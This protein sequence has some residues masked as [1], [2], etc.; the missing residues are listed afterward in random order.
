[1]SEEESRALRRAANQRGQRGLSAL[2]SSM[3]RRQAIGMGVVGGVSLYLF[4]CG[5]SDGDSTSAGTV[6][7]ATE[8]STKPEQLIVRNWGDPWSTTWQASAGK[9]FE[10]DT[11]IKVVWDTTDGQVIQSKIQTAIRADSRPPVDAVVNIETLSYLSSVQGLSLAMNPDLIP[12]IASL[13]NSTAHPD[14]L[15]DW[16]YM[17]L[18]TYLH[19]IVYNS[20]KMDAP[21]SWEDLY[22]PSLAGRIQMTSAYTSVMYP[23]AKMLGLTP[24]EDDMGP[25]WD[26][27]VELRPNIGGQGDSTDFVKGAVS[28]DYWCG[29][30]LA[31]DAAAAVEQGVPIKAAVPKE[32]AVLDRDCYYVLNNLP[33]EV[34]YYAQVFC[35]YMV[36]KEAQTAIMSKNKVVPVNL[37]VELSKEMQADPRVYPF[38]EDEVAEVGIIPTPS[39]A[40]KHDADWQAQYDRAVKG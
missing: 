18:Y 9:A 38:T 14:G 8:P 31:G 22:D 27:I 17:G 11:G 13:N 36:S 10:A 7:S 26:K 37:D 12:N 24:G 6:A 33:D 29:M 3:T 40:A 4:G 21:T 23:F 25:V 20:D 34:T 39:V 35:N 2:D 30:Q 16:A 28:G 1:M 15:D 5:G 19:P 32:G